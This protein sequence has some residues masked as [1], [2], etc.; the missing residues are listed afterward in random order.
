MRRLQIA[1]TLAAVGAAAGCVDRELGSVTESEASTLYVTLRSELWNVHTLVLGAG[2][3]PPR[4]PYDY[5]CAAGLITLRVGLD[6]DMQPASLSHTIDACTVDGVGVTLDGRIEYRDLDL[7]NEATG[8]F[9]FS[10]GGIIDLTGSMNGFCY[11]EVRDRCG[12]LTGHV[13]GFAA[14]DIVL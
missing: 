10:A 3:E 8:E 9:A 11:I 4:E 14:A 6:E 1:L 12:K 2:G 13:C 5:G 7:C